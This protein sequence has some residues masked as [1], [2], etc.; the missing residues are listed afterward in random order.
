MFVFNTWALTRCVLQEAALDKVKQKL[1]KNRELIDND[2][3]LPQED[4]LYNELASA[5]NSL[6]AKD[7]L[8][9]VRVITEYEIWMFYLHASFPSVDL[10]L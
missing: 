8:I 3:K 2:G 7:N 4:E 9:Q 5:A 10:S 6:T 1:K